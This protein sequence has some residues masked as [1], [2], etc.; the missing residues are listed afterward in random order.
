[1]PENWIPRLQSPNPAAADLKKRPAVEGVSEE[2]NNEKVIPLEDLKQAK[3]SGFE[4]PNEGRA[5]GF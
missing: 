5:P 2:G 1:M 3:K 4:V